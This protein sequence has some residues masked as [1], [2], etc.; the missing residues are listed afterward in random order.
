MRK[1]KILLVV[2]VAL[3]LVFNAC[4]KASTS[5][6]T[7]STAD[8]RSS[9][10]GVS[11]PDGGDVNFPSDFLPLLPKE[12]LQAGL[13]NGK[14]GGFGG[15]V[16]L[17]QAGNRAERRYRPVILLHGQ[18]GRANGDDWGFHAIYQKLIDAGY[19]PSEIWAIS[20][21]GKQ[22]GML[23]DGELD[24]KDATSNMGARFFQYSH[25]V[26]EVRAFILAVM[27][28]TNAKKVDIVAHSL[29]VVMARLAIHG[30]AGSYAG[31]GYT[32]AQFYPELELTEK[33]GSVILLA[34][35]NYG[36]KKGNSTYYDEWDGQDNLYTV[37]NGA[38]NVQKVKY[39]AIKSNSGWIDNA[40]RSDVLPSG[41]SSTSHLKGAFVNEAF[42]CTGYS[43]M[44]K[45]RGITIDDQVF[46][47]YKQFLCN[48]DDPTPNTTINPNGG[49][50]YP[51]QNV[52]ITATDNPTSIEYQI[53][54]ADQASPVESNWQAYTG[55][56][57]IDA[58]CVIFARAANA[59]GMG[60]VAN[61]T[62]T[63]K[64]P[65]V[66]EVAITPAGQEFGE[67]VNAQITATEDPTSIEYQ[68][69]PEGQTLGSTWTTY[70]AGSNITITESCTLY[71]RATNAQGTGEAQ[72]SFTKKP[73]TVAEGTLTDH[74]MAGRVNM[75]YPG[76]FNCPN[77]YMYL[78]QRHSMNSFE[79]YE[80]NG[81]WTDVKP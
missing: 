60:G 29:G 3:M 31:N 1:L 5:F 9:T 66:P 80:V 50:F 46:D 81:Q 42:N 71:A 49:N 20:Y 39:I 56:F 10:S 48:E 21:L 45:H 43:E 25:N 28:Y 15:N 34:G 55:A 36:I 7:A 69:V 78:F 4:S 14:V 63:L 64:V 38:A 24:P 16:N 65:G 40:T 52:T 58:S 59:N 54:A 33:V 18:G 74:Y 47:Y 22:E 70:T 13:P 17:D 68:I 6:P 41:I 53:G 67:S 44:Q 72:A 27:Q 51:T 12:N 62:F 32:R 26:D 77:G 61:A 37:I 35:A 2:F 76:M 30:F 75:T 57:T 23:Q 8:F 73:Y 79:M 11:G 19:K